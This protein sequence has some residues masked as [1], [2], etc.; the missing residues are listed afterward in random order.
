MPTDLCGVVDAGAIAVHENGA[1]GQEAGA[2]HARV[3]GAPAVSRGSRAVGDRGSR[4][5]HVDAHLS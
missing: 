5:V 1:A 4:H 2:Q 3:V